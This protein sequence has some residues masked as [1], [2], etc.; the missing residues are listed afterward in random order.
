MSAGFQEQLRAALERAC[1]AQN[2]SVIT[3]GRAEILAMPRDLVLQNIEALA[4]LTLPLDEDWEYR[5]LLELFAE[6]DAPL[7]QRLI[8]RGLKSAN[9]EVREAAQDFAT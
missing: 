3:R 2:D 8:T 4:P 5:R 7:L 6:L 9:P 1:R